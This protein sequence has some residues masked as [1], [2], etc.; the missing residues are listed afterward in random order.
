MISKTCVIDGYVTLNDWEGD[1]FNVWIY[2]AWFGVDL[3]GGVC[4]YLHLYIYIYTN[5]IMYIYIYMLW[6]IH[7]SYV[8]ENLSSLT[9][10]IMVMVPASNSRDSHLSRS[11]HDSRQIMYNNILY[12]TTLAFQFLW[13]CFVQLLSLLVDVWKNSLSD[14]WFLASFV[15]VWR[16]KSELITKIQQIQEIHFYVG[17]ILTYSN[18]YKYTPE[19]TLI[20][21]DKVST[22]S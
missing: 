18:N 8:H 9:W 10:Y 11:W 12:N 19:Q 5:M 17:E 2:L 14:G 20:K 15:K 21:S 1:M 13:V 4:I 22:R 3:C 16:G 6:H 7:M